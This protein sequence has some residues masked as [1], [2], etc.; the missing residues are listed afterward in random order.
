MRA[1]RKKQRITQ[2]ELADK[3]GFAMDTISRWE[4]G[5][6]SPT[7]DD[8][9]KIAKILNVAVSY[10]VSEDDNSDPPQ[11]LSIQDKYGFSNPSPTPARVIGIVKNAQEFRSGEKISPK[12]YFDL[13]GKEHDYEEEYLENLKKSGNVR[14]FDRLSHVNVAT[15]DKDEESKREAEIIEKIVSNPRKYTIA[16]LIADMDE[17]QLRK[18]FDYLSDQK[19]LGELEKLKGQS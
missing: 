5:D 2:T 17:N 19:R 10:L 8:L 12:F 9:Q 18:A 3:A 7:I 11:S 1:I 4:R 14:F 16:T 13:E 15:M 6:R